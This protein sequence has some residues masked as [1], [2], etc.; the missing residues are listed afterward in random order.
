M[1]QSC[2]KTILLLLCAVTV[3]QLTAQNQ[4]LYP[5]IINVNNRNLLS[6]EGS[7][8]TIVDP[9]ENGY[10]DYRL[11]PL[12]D[13]YFSDREYTNHTKL[14][15]Y[16]FTNEQTLAVPGDWN[17]QRPQLYYYEGTVWYRKRFD[18]HPKAGERYFLYFGAV[19]YEAKVYFNGQ[20]T[21][22]HVGGFTPFNIEV[23][24]KIK[25]GENSI[26]V[27]A[28][29]KRKPEAVPTVNAD[30]WNFGGITRQVSLITVPS[31]FIRDYKI[32]LAKGNTKLLQGW[33]QLDGAA[34]GEKVTIGIP[35][36]SIEK[37]LVVNDAGFAALEIP[38]KKLTLWEP[39]NPK[40]YDVT[41]STPDDR[42]TDKI[43]FR[44][45]ETRGTDILLNGKKLFCR[46]IS[47]HEETADYS[48]RAYNESQAVTLLSW[49]K[50]L[51][52]NFIRLAHYPHNEFMVRT[53]ERMGL[54]VWSEIPVYWTIHWENK[55]TYE[56]AEKQLQDMITRDKNR[57]NVIIWSVA[58]ETP[59]GEPRL[60]FLSNL[61]AKTRSLDD[62]RLVAAA[63]EKEEIRPGELTVHDA[64][65]E[66]L[67]LISFN[68]YVGWYDG[69]W[70][71]CDRVN[72]SFNVKKPV[73]ISE[74]GGD[75][76]YGLHG[77]DTERFTEE[78][79][80]RLY[81]RSIEMLKR[82]DGL[83]GITPWI[84]K[85]FR[86][87]RRHLRDIQDDFNRKGLVSD[88]GQHKKAF[89]VLKK[90]YDEIDGC[91]RK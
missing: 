11:Q 79:Q 84:L 7:W 22:T 27:K 71:K 16:D 35:E 60:H 67:D 10:Y 51:G 62:T 77:K 80:E 61:I 54:M 49:A 29:N 64:L 76:Q 57:A 2:K 73:F 91:S 3:F 66:L 45:I 43:G 83:A 69:E 44:T 81:E 85:D 72:W 87:P 33:V 8:K 65:G 19:N 78:Y 75:A 46:G 18:F 21:G 15:E 56:N 13:G 9:F 86:S 58:N 6:L 5:Q 40:L 59:V 23:T 17:T 74:M 32:Q 89:Y 36:L 34:A 63:M 38:L 90:W 30:W 50:E 68:Q 52:C 88:K 31:H 41:L 20:L 24:G 12:K 25:T 82:I 37:T 48:G 70:D 14:Q 53:A 42:I 39:E 26:V 55:D 47:I 1:K 4:N 28:D